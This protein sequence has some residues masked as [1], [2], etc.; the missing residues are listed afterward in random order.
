LIRRGIEWELREGG[1]YCS[2]SVTG[3]RN[4]WRREMT[5][6]ADRWVPVSVRKSE[7]PYRFGKSG[8]WAAAD[9]WSWAGMA[10]PS[11]FLFFF[12]LSS[13]LFLFSYLIHNFC[14]IHPNQFKPFSKIF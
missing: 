12:V 9:F 10:P 7:G 14:K 4:G 13:F 1:R 3:G 6:S 5:G 8:G 2:A 11:L